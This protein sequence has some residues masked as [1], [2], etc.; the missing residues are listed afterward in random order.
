M[1]VRQATTEEL[2]AWCAAN[3]RMAALRIE[4]LVNTVL[5]SSRELAA[6]R[7]QVDTM[8]VQLDQHRDWLAQAQAQHAAVAIDVARSADAALVDATIAEGV[9]YL[10][11]R[12]DAAEKIAKGICS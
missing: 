4:N 5:A 2:A 8:Q 7:A 11:G 3:P 10:R 6:L 9:A 1:R 12:R